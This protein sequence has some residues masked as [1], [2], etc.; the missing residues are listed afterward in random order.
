MGAAAVPIIAAVAAAG[1]Q[2]FS[3]A[4]AARKQDREAF[5]G[6]QKQRETQKQAD[7]RIKQTLADLERSSSKE[8]KETRGAQ[9]RDQ[10]RKL[11]SLGLAGIQATGG[12]DAAEDLADISRGRA[13]DF[14]DFIGNNLAGVDAAGLQRQQEGFDAGDLNADLG[15]FRRNSAQDA[16]LSRLRQQGIRP[17]PLLGLVSAGLSG[18]ATSG[19]GTGGSIAGSGGTGALV[20]GSTQTPQT[21]FSASSARRLPGQIGT[22][23]GKLF[24]IFGP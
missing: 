4:K 3:Q 12:S 19:F 21:F 8:H 22:P 13:V 16:N 20:N 18:L 7:A 15:I 6:L 24:N 11:Q 5:E 10:Q 23:T 2:Q 1:V 14:G 17:S 9:I